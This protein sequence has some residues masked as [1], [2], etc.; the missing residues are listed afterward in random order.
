MSDAIF[1]PNAKLRTSAGRECVVEEYL[2]SGGEGEVY[3]VR[4][5]GK[6]LALKWYYPDTARP[7]RLKSLRDLARSGAP[8]ERFLWPR[9]VIEE[10]G[11]FG[12]VMPLRPAEY[13]NFNGYLRRK[14]TLGYS[15]AANAALQL[16]DSFRKLHIKGFSYQDISGGNIFLNPR[17]GSILICDNDNVA[18]HGSATGNIQ[19]TPKFMAPE[20]VRGEQRPDVYTD[21]YSLA[22]LLFEILFIG[23]PL[24]GQKW[25]D[26]RCLDDPAMKKLYGSEPVFIY[27]PVNA[28]N[29]PVPGLQNNPILFWAMYPRYIQECFIKSFTLGLSDRENGRLIEDEWLDAFR[30][31]RES[32]VYCQNCGREVMYDIGLLQSGVPMQCWGKNCG[33]TVRLP[34]RLR[35]GTGKR[36]RIVMLN[37]SAKLYAYQLKPMQDLATGDEIVGEVAQNPNDPS[38]WGLR[39]LSSENW[40]YASEQGESK[41]VPPGRSVS[42]VSG[43][44]IRFN[45]AAEGEIK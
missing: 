39:N 20:I 22:V 35:I 8:D 17:D 25:A 27:D 11:L 29:R 6:P 31:L 12:Y 3:R 34:P 2:G 7:E 16:A 32:I 24:E 23:H 30:K 1:K 36:E 9:D 26:I 42:L 5:D 33:Q 44:R 13:Q 18:P 45:S 15:G 43:L 4:V 28:G 37:A 40:H 10:R 38:V 19:G 21:R 14:Y 41:D